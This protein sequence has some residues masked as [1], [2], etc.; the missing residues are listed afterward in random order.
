[1]KGA[2][3]AGVCLVVDPPRRGLT[4]DHPRGYAALTA[5]AE[6]AAVRRG[7]PLLTWDRQPLEGFESHPI[8]E[9][10]R[11]YDLLVIDHP[12]IG[13]AVA[14]GCLVSL[15]DV[16]DVSLIAD[17]STR[18]MGS[19]MAS[20]AW[21]G[22]HWALPLD[23]ATQVM[24]LRP[25][26]LAGPQPGT[27]D[28]VV[29]MSERC[30]VTVSVAGPHA[31]LHLFALCAALGAEPGRED[32]LASAPF[33]EAW[34]ILTVLHARSPRGTTSLNPIELLETMAGSNAIALVPLVYG[35]VNYA[36]PAGGRHAVVFDDAPVAV[37]GGR[38]GSVLGGTGI[39]ITRRARVSPEL[40]AHLVWLLSDEAQTQ[41]IPFHE[42]Q[43]S[44]RAA[45]SDDA[46]NARWAGFYHRTAGTVAAALVRPRH[47]GYIA[48]QARA[49][50]LIR[51]A[52]HDG[53]DAITILDQLRAAW[54][55]SL[56]AAVREGTFTGAR[57][58]P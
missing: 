42:G 28:D 43:P 31:V 36:V 12:H 1:M 54:R 15:E 53:T 2:S 51:A 14:E 40:H 20:Y 9:L 6:C 44:A 58:E 21:G 22:Q 17:W 39:A 37:S 18:T 10:A 57:T 46:V 3:P 33:V 4:W 16:F 34:R 56:A 52:L 50:A 24:A 29:R 41:F 13:E 26:L 35:Y 55:N 47:A 8:G 49:S 32:L 19:A 27:W 25:D 11:H 45:W 30:A 23:V 7:G 5:A 48:F 38:H